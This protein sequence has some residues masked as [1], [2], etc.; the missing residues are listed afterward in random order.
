ME[1]INNEINSSNNSSDY[2][3]SI[4]AAA[5]PF[6]QYP[7]VYSERFTSLRFFVFNKKRIKN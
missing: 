7:F 4:A 6:P 5:T 1:N 3:L 2:L